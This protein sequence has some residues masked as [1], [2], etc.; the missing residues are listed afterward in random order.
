MSGEETSSEVDKVKVSQDQ[1]ALLELCAIRVNDKS[2]DWSVLAREATRVG[3]I[4]DLTQGLL[5]EK[6]AAAKRTAELIHKGLDHRDEWAARVDDELELAASVGARLI[7]VLDDNYPVNLRL[8]YNLPP[9]LFVRGTEW[10]DG[11]VRS[12]AVVGTRNP[13]PLGRKRAGQLA[14]QLTKNGVVVISGLAR[15]IDSAAHEATLSAGGRTIAVIGTGITQTYPKENRELAE[16]IVERGVVVSQFWP[17]T[18]PAKWTFPRRNVVMSGIAQGTAVVEASS[19]SGARM[20]A[21]LALEHGKK[22]FLLHSLITDQPW[23]QKFVADRGAIEVASVEEIVER[24]AA[25]E[26]VQAVS[27]AR[28]LTLGLA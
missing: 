7:T 13:S 27:T 16:R 19:T 1:R 18:S 23:A 25:P 10:S 14:S 22:V 6:S 5:T 8:I 24:L 15:G 21:R 3:A 2:P 12:V 20:Q 17:S 11:D 26:R 28:Q 9:F 4:A